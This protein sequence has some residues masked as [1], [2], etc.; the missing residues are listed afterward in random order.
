MLLTM[1][2]AAATFVST[3]AGGT[4]AIRW[5]GRLE[6]LL[7]V[8]GGVVIGAAVFDLLPEAV[9]HARASGVPRALP[10][11]VALLGYASFRVL[12]RRLHQQDHSHGPGRMGTAGAA[13]FTVHSFFDGLAIGLGFHLSDGVGVIVALAVIG[14][15]FSDGLNTVS[16]LIAHGHGRVRQWR[17]LLAD[18]LSP[19]VGAAVAALA[20]VPDAV[21]PIALGF[22][23]GVFVYAA[24]ANLLPR[25]LKAPAVRVVPLAVAGATLMFGI[26]R[27]A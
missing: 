17:W 27:F 26:S 18:A 6:L 19:V 16:Y 10:F 20:P 4:A 21:F 9:D 11:V 24:S 25:A 23:A 15:D 7:A 12:E 8:A 13:G 2:F 5:P 1:L 22:F 3:M 14:H